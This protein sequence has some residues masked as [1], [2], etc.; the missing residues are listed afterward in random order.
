M[1]TKRAKEERQ[2]G[3]KDKDLVKK[4]E[5]ITKRNLTKQS[6][7]IDRTKLPCPVTE[8]EGQTTENTRDRKR[9]QKN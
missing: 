1:R 2:G 8:D 7:R 6:Q 5:M 3:R 9:D 4:T